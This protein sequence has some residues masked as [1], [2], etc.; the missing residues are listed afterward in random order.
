MRY[1]EYLPG[2]EFASIVERFWLLE[3]AAAGAPDAIIPDGR[4]EVVFH[5][6]G[7]FWRHLPDERPIRQPASLLVGQMVEPV[8]LAP[9]GESGVAA[10]RLMP[11]AARTFLGFP[12]REIAGRFV[13][14]DAVCASTGE[15]RERLAEAGGDAARIQLLEAWLRRLIR[16]TTRPQMDA[17]VSAIVQSGGRAPIDRIAARTGLGVRQIERHFHDEVGLGPKTFARIVRLQAALAR[18]RQGGASS[19]SDV[20]IACGYYD[21]A[22]MARDFR[23]LA[24]M[25]PTVWQA[26]AGEL[27]PLFISSPS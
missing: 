17:A 15:L 21:Q 16:R 4:V 12:A 19:L 13:E 11:A 25:S 24:A 27:A 8:V 10:I 3:G 1:A 20:A 6:G 7:T 26:H 18:I 22:H 2:P 5:Y 9:E 14:L 23:Q